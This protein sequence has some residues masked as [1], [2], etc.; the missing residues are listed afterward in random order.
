MNVEQIEELIQ[1]TIQE[2]HDILALDWRKAVLFLKG[3]GITEDNI[4]FVDS[5]FAKAIMIDQ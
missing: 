4:D 5:D 1:P 2:I 3:T